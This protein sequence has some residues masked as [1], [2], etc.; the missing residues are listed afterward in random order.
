MI[1]EDGA[2]RGYKSKVND[3]NRFETQ[4]AVE[5]LGHF[6]CHTE[7]GAY[8]IYLTSSD[9]VTVTTTG[10]IILLLKNDYDYPLVI[11]RIVGTVGSAGVFWIEKGHTL[12]TLGNV[13]DASVVNLNFASSRTPSATIKA[14]N[15][16]GDGITGITGGTKVAPLWVPAATVIDL[17]L[18]DMFILSQG[19]IFALRAKGLGG[20]MTTQIYLSMYYD[21]I[22]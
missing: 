17:D 11:Q 6:Y 22:A 9:Y 8:G 12:G 4:A 15:G 21:T 20:T 16:T 3:K 2:G 14:W 7:A 5:A 1:I 18:K 19:S 13:G 10:G